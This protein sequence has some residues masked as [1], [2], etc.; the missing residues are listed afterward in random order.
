MC[1][2]LKVPYPRVSYFSVLLWIE[3]GPLLQRKIFNNLYIFSAC[4]S[5]ALASPTFWDLQGNLGFTFIASP[6]GLFECNSLKG[7]LCITLHQGAS[8]SFLNTQRQDHCIHSTL[9]PSFQG[10]LITFSPTSIG[11]TLLS[12]PIT[13]CCILCELTEEILV[14]NPTFFLLWFS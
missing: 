10:Q 2:G 12:L 3:P 13:H 9:L 7:G 11:D 4:I 14:K 8:Q 6:K 1:S 5:M